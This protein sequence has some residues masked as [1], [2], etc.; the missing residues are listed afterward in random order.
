MTSTY[1]TT[2]IPYRLG[3]D[4]GSTTV[5]AAVLDSE[6][7]LIFSC[8]ERHL[9][10][11]AGTIEKIL[12]QLAAVTGGN[13]VRACMTGSGGLSISEKLGLPFVQEV[14]A[15]SRAVRTFHPEVTAVLELGGEDA[16]LT[17]FDPGV[18]QRMNGICA[19]GTGAFIDQMAQLLKTDAAGLNELAARHKTLYPIAAR[20][21]VFAKTDV[22]ALLNEGAGREDIAASILQAVVNQ[23]IAGLSCGRKIRGHVCFI[24]GPLHFLPQLRLRFQETLNLGP[25]ALI[26]PD[27]APVFVAVGAALSAEEAPA[28]TLRQLTDGL[29][30]TASL[31][32]DTAARLPALFEDEAT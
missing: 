9:S 21:G 2:A 24:G 23:T 4:I 17:F 14:I 5:K 8:Y 19:G 12:A 30:A 20:C 6:D 32:N 18:D 11:L 3:I 31:N 22:Q 15:G 25:E 7:K 1:E 27:N 16:K 13:P 29:R 26:T 28:V 10:D